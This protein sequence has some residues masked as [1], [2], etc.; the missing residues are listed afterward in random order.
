MTQVVNRCYHIPPHLDEEKVLDEIELSQR[1]SQ[2]VPESV[3]I[4]RLLSKFQDEHV[5]IAREIDPIT[6]VKQ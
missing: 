2:I 5:F 1:A 3:T 6:Y 4:G